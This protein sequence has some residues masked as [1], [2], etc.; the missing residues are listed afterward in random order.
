MISTREL[1]MAA[2]T[3]I[4]VGSEVPATLDRVGPK[5][6]FSPAGAVVRSLAGLALPAPQMCLKRRLSV[7]GSGTG[8]R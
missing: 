8:L 4:A 2:I 1:L 5:Q 7:T 6:L 3:V